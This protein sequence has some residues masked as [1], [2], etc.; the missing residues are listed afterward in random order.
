M[1]RT[2]PTRFE[3]LTEF[4][5]LYYHACWPFLWIAFGLFLALILL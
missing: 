4:A 2:T 5:I 1:N 3:T